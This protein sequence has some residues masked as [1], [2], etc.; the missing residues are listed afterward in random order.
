[1]KNQLTVVIMS[2]IIILVACLF[3]SL[4]F[5]T[6]TT[7]KIEK[8]ENSGVVLSNPDPII[9]DRIHYFRIGLTNFFSQQDSVN[10]SFSIPDFKTWLSNKVYVWPNFQDLCCKSLQSSENNQL[11]CSCDNINIAFSAIKDYHFIAYNENIINTIESSIGAPKEKN[12]TMTIFKNDYILMKR[13]IL[14]NI[15]KPIQ[16]TS[17]LENTF[18]RVPLSGSLISF[19]LCRPLLISFNTTGLYMIKHEDI[20]NTTKMEDYEDNYKSNLFSY[21]DSTRKTDNYIYLKQIKANDVDGISVFQ[22]GKSNILRMYDENKQTYPSTIYYFNY[23]EE[24][25][26]YDTDTQVANFIINEKLY[27]SSFGAGN[28]LRMTTEQNDSQKVETVLFKKNDDGLIQFTIDSIEYDI[29]SAFEYNDPAKY[30]RFDMLFTI[31]HDILLISCFSIEKYSKRNVCISIRYHLPRKFVMKKDKYLTFL[32]NNSPI[33]NDIFR[34]K[35]KNHM[36]PTSI[37][38]LI[39]ISYA[40]GYVFQIQ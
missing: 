6:K 22:Q 3:G 14:L 17:N 20:R 36:N 13:G 33:M 24:H 5:K 37:P 32:E 19:V 26:L 12:C 8:Y 9:S 27:N 25:K 28:Q 39:Q 16:E 35:L 21:F 18:F 31:S 38:N 1:M 23:K 30:E 29:P 7:P 10:T 34:K 15:P 11:N 4:T 2:L 40:M